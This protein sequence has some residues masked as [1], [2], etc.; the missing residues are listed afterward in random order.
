MNETKVLVA[1]GVCG[2]DVEC[3]QP[4]VAKHKV[5]WSCRSSQ[6]VSTFIHLLFVAVATPPMHFPGNQV[7]DN[8]QHQRRGTSTHP[9]RQQTENQGRC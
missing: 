2:T 8:G 1:V 9:R 5:V 7:E 4:P 6:I 3:D